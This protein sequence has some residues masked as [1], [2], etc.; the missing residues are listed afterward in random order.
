MSL[1]GIRGTSPARTLLDL[2]SQLP[3]TALRRAVREAMAQRDVAIRQ[4][5]DVIARTGPRRGSRK[6]A[7][8]IADGYTPTRSVLEDIVLDLILTGGFERPDVGKPLVIA[9]RRIVPDFR[10]PAHRLI[11]E[12]DGA[13]WHDN[14]LAREDDAERQALLEAS[15]ERVLRVT[16]DDAVRKQQQTWARL[17][18]ADAPRRTESPLT[19]S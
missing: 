2:A 19:R 11:V 15:G 5:A 6:L 13:Q 10:W 9:A 18:G 4:L 14:M 7:D 17:A 12:A 8:V 3:P 16:W 1:G